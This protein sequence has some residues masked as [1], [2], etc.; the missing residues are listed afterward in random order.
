VGKSL[1]VDEGKLLS[2]Y[3]SRP[4]SLDPDVLADLIHDE[5]ETV[6]AQIELPTRAAPVPAAPR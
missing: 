3:E 2:D 4:N 5:V 6:Q 1:L